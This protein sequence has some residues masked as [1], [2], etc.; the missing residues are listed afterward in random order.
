MKN[1]KYSFTGSKFKST[2]IPVKVLTGII[3][4]TTEDTEITE[5]YESPCPLCS[6]WLI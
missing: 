4:F 1:F 6:L 5:G 3:I 2:N